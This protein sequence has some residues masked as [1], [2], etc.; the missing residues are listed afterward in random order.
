MSRLRWVADSE[1]AFASSLCRSHR[2]DLLRREASTSDLSQNLTAAIGEAASEAGMRAGGASR[3]SSSV[4]KRMDA[5]WFDGE[6]RAQKAVTSS[7]LGRLKDGNYDS[8]L[9]LLYCEC[10]K[11]YGA[12]LE[13]KRRDYEESIANGFANI[14]NPKAFWEVVKSCRPFVRLEPTIDLTVWQAFLVEVYP[15]HLSPASARPTSSTLLSMLL[16]PYHRSSPAYA[17]LRQARLQGKMGS[18]TTF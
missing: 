17:L 15:L 7:A 9:R 6:C 2:L 11:R 16:S 13:A 8:H 18:V 12:L 14:K 4:R 1:G 10:K 5:P 3:S